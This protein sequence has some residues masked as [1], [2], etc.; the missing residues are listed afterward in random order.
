MH[1]LE[2]KPLRRRALGKTPMAHASENIRPFDV[3]AQA[4]THTREDFTRSY[5]EDYLLL[6]DLSGHEEAVANALMECPTDPSRPW[7]PRS[8]ST[9]TGTTVTGDVSI[10]G[11]RERIAS[12]PPPM[13]GDMLSELLQ[14]PHFVMP[15]RKRAQ[16]TMEAERISIGRSHANDIVLFHHTVSK[17]HAWLEHDDNG[18]LF[19]CDARSTNFTRVRGSIVEAGDLVHFRYGEPLAFGDVHARVCTADVLW[20]AISFLDEDDE[21]L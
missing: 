13:D 8:E 21:A 11:L 6:V 9:G 1:G 19:V 17:L 12:L 14:A 16:A 2:P 15:L 18:R 5:D 20:D 4:R 7:Y 10:E 3:V